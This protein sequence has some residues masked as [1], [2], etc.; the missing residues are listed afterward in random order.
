MQ[1]SGC[2]KSSALVRGVVW[3]NFINAFWPIRIKYSTALRWCV[4]Q[5]LYGGVE[6]LEKAPEKQWYL[7]EWPELGTIFSGLITKR[8]GGKK[9]N[10]RNNKALMSQMPKIPDQFLRDVQSA[11]FFTARLQRTEEIDLSERAHRSRRRN[12]ALIW[13]GRYKFK[14]VDNSLLGWWKRSDNILCE[15]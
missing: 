6:G 8:G 10:G 7:R 2:L 1:F 12:K 5:D 9:R 13:P 11:G 14:K 15:I 4:L 3:E